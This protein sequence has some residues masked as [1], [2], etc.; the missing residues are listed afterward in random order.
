MV[1]KNH[2][3]NMSKSLG[4]CPTKLSESDARHAI[5][6]ISSGK[7]DTAVQVHKVLQSITNQDFSVHTVRRKLKQAGMKSAV[8]KKRPF[9]SKHHQKQRLDFAIAHQDWTVEDWKR[10]IWSD[11][12]KINRLGSD[13]RKWVWKKPGEAL[14]GRIIEPTLKFGGGSLMIWGCFTWNG[15]GYACKIDGKMD[16]DLYCQILEDDLQKTIDYYGLEADNI[17]FQ[18]DNDPKHTSKRPNSGSK[19]MP[20][21]F[22]L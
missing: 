8:K 15:V 7:A 11:E 13:G 3:P 19:T 2:R 6:L 20:F 17:I 10:V 5:R 4:G 14:S 22:F 9:L 18:Q 1:R 21:H 16:A 12:T